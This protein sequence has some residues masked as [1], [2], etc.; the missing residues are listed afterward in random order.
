MTEYKTPEAT[1]ASNRRFQHDRHERTL[2]EAVNR[3]QIW[4]SQEDEVVLAHNGTDEAIAYLLGRT[5]TAVTQRRVTLR[6][7]LESGMTIEEIH[8]AEHFTRT[9]KNAAHVST[10]KS[11]VANACEECFCYP[12]MV[13]CSHA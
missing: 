2:K 13:G 11:I 9:Q 3:G 10:V 1:R 4:S 12:H 8:E 7:L 6:K 5:A